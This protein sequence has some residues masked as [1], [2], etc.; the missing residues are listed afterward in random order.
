MAAETPSADDY[1]A[2]TEHPVTQFVMAG[3]KR[4]AD[5]QKQAWSDMAWSGELDPLVRERARTR[6]D[7]YA[8]LSHLSYDDALG[9]NGVEKVPQ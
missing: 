5:G 8:D 1:A 4:L 7:A 9:A 3:L 2:W 6:A